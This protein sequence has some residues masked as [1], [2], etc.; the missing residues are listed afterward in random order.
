MTDELALKVIIELLNRVPK[1]TA[2]LV[3]VQAALQHI[4]E[5]LKPKPATD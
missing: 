5:R 2:E 1:N 3:G 4:E